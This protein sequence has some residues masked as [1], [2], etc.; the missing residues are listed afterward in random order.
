VRLVEE[1]LEVEGGR[2]PTCGECL[3]GG[4]FSEVGE[5]GEMFEEEKE[6][7]E[8]E[9]EKDY[10]D[11]EEE[12][13]F[14]D[15]PE[16]A[17]L[18]SSPQWN[19]AHSIPSSCIA[20]LK[21]IILL[22]STTSTTNLKKLLSANP[23][24]LHTFLAS[25]AKIISP[26]QLS[27]LLTSLHRLLNES[28]KD[29]LTI[30]RRTMRGEDRNDLTM[31]ELLDLIEGEGG[32]RDRGEEEERKINDG[33]VGVV[34]FSAGLETSEGA[35][36]V[37][38]V[39]AMFQNV[40]INEILSLISPLILD[41]EIKH[42]TITAS[43]S[44]L[45]ELLCLPDFTSYPVLLSPTSKC[46]FLH[47]SLTKEGDL[48][49]VTLTTDRSTC[50][51]DTL[52]LLKTETD[53]E[54]VIICPYFKSEF[55]TKFS[56][57]HR[58]EEGEG[59]G[60][61][62]ELFTLLGEEFVSKVAFTE[63]SEL[64]EW[65]EA[66][67]TKKRANHWIAQNWTRWRIGVGASFCARGLF[68]NSPDQ[69]KHTSM[70]E[71]EASSNTPKLIYYSSPQFHTQDATLKATGVEGF[72]ELEIDGDQDLDLVG[73][74]VRVHDTNTTSIFTITSS[75]PTKSR[76]Y[77]I[78]PSLLTSYSKAF[79]GIG[80]KKTPILVYKKECEGVWVNVGVR[81]GGGMKE[82]YRFFGKLMG[83]TV[84]NLTKVSIASE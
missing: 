35:G 30:A 17:L 65:S 22:S 52:E 40:A 59:L 29:K 75:H 21:E 23:N 58:V 54:T 71:L 84:A 43:L 73:K 36:E 46:L 80:T 24:L 3:E 18:E 31:Q 5:G 10:Y 12:D 39:Q 7:E 42:Q 16:T 33:I 60:P 77:K 79:V 19:S 55:G 26:K 28:L 37:V 20:E 57:G 27:S 38:D 13:D 63:V 56:E 32:N 53:T 50:T 76:T 48:R 49:R 15:D 72:N 78:A 41:T 44:S 83:L 47:N 2:R 68:R 70:G 1:M 82:M 6:K 64:V 8:E 74:T 61:R 66:K 62:K 4:F 81:E 9:E 25:T 14:N 51:A 67:K 11:Y 45:S 69:G 34:Q